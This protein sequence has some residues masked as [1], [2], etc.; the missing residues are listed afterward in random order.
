MLAN[1]A[2]GSLIDGIR[3]NPKRFVYSIFTVY[4]ICWAIMEPFLAIVPSVAHSFPSWNRYWVLLGISI[5]VGGIRARKVY[6][7][8]I[9]FQNN[10]IR[11]AFG[12]L[13]DESGIKVIPVSQFM[14]EIDVVP[15]S[16]QANLISRFIQSN[17]GVQGVQK[18]KDALDKALANSNSNEVQRGKS[19][20]SEKKFHVGTTALITHLQSKYIL[21]A[22][23]ETESPNHIPQSNCDSQRLW[24]AMSMMWADARKYSRG[25]NLSIPLI[26]SGVSGL[27]LEPEKLLELTMLSLVFAIVEGGMV[28]S[29][30]ISIILHPRLSGTIDLM[31]FIRPWLNMSVSV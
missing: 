14:Y 8:R 2:L 24:N 4:G 7:V 22:L 20:E 6:E 11:V 25:N 19:S 16:I 28:T 31:E 29:G 21:L 23:T 30:T 17:E 27:Q 1:N 3:L 5:L 9:R 12:D 15:S 10:C 18:Y 26:G 13:F